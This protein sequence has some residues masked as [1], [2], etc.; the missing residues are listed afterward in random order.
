MAQ[1]ITVVSDFVCPYCYWLEALMERLPE[2]PAVRYAPYQLTRRGQEPVDVAADPERRARY[3]QT[4]APAC[5]AL[6]VDMH[7]PP[8]VSP[9]PYTDLAFQGWYFAREQGA[10]DRFYEWVFRAY[11]QEE[12][13]IGDVEVL[14]TLAQDVG[15]DAAA[16]RR[17]LEDGIYAQAVE[18]DTDAT[19]EGLEIR[20]VPT[21]VCG[22][23]RLEGF[24]PDVETLQRWLEETEKEDA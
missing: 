12:R 16:L 9:R 22:E 5:A 11:F 18:R 8:R 24:V 19:A 17:A 3:A 14:C 7:L 4:L 6:G 2:H 10:G 13:D 1:E 21:L 15:L 20:M 23:H